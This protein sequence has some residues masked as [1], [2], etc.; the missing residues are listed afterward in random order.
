MLVDTPKHSPRHSGGVIK[1]PLAAASE[2]KAAVP[3][4]FL[5]PSPPVTWKQA[6]RSRYL[7]SEVDGNIGDSQRHQKADERPVRA[8]RWK[9]HH[10]TSRDDRAR[11]ICL[12]LDW[13]GGKSRRLAARRGS[14]STC[15]SAVGGGVKWGS[16]G[17]CASRGCGAAK[18]IRRAM[19]I[20]H[21]RIFL[22]N[23]HHQGGGEE[24]GDARWHQ[25]KKGGDWDEPRWR[26][27][28]FFFFFLKEGHAIIRSSSAG[29]SVSDSVVFDFTAPV[30]G[31][32]G[33]FST[34]PEAGTHCCPHVGLASR[35]WR[36]RQV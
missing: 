27:G 3:W 21:R 28:F 23:R 5:P 29:L 4:V 9:L 20:S 32:S 7:F 10:S 17:G 15:V 11:G 26:F 8:E 19:E 18:R 24:R 30:L 35:P 22:A 31:Q 13:W 34:L 14:R 6:S 1:R 33:C 25:T 12:G 36:H 16:G 2:A